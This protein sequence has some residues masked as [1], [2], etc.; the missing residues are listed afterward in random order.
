MSDRW[1]SNGSSKLKVQLKNGAY[2]DPES[3]LESKGHVYRDGKEIYTAVLSCSDVATGKNSYYKLQIIESD[4]RNKWWLFKAWGRIGTNIG[5]SKVEDYG[6]AGS[7]VL[8]FEEKFL[9]QTG[10]EWSAKGSFKKRAGKY[11]M[12]DIDFGQGQQEKLIKLEDG[13]IGSKLV[14]PV[15]DLMKML[16]NVEAMKETMLEFE[17]D[18]EKMPLGKLTQRQIRAAYTELAKLQEGIHGDQKIAQSEIVAISNKFYTMIPHSAGVDSLPRLD[19][20]EII[21]VKI[22]L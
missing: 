17:L 20:E 5:K 4:K 7:A 2:V 14:T 18:L 3:N 11:F 13:A 22:I 1:L 9:E 12:Q 6:D 8:D 21:K 10:N 15:Q 16:F 19:N